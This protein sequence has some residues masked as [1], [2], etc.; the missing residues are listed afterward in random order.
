[1]STFVQELKTELK[2]FL[3]WMFSLLLIVYFGLIKYENLL[4]PGFDIN[5]LM[6]QF[7]KIILAVFG[8]L[9]IDVM[10]LDG[11]YSVIG[12]L[13]LLF[14]SIY[15]LRLGHALISREIS[16]QTYEFLFSKPISRSNVLIRKFLAHCFYLVLAVVLLS[17]VSMLSVLALGLKMEITT[18]IWTYGLIILL[19]SLLFYWLSAFLTSLLNNINLSVIL[20][21]SLYFLFF[22]LSVL[23]DMLENAD[24]LRFL[25]PF[26][27]F[28][29]NEIIN[30]D[31]PS[32]FLIY[33]MF[34]ILML[35]YLTFISFKKKDLL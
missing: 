11:Y 27:F 7:P 15:G 34:L 32:V 6:D 1:M 13:N 28:M 31:I 2:P 23:Y 33:S 4:I 16:D 25:T 18:L 35:T 8:M 29:A 24:V 14:M 26:K 30:Q 17:A 12:Y 5:K 10:S 19:V 20:S 9:N 22:I 21:T 3:W